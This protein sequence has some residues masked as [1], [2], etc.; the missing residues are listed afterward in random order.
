VGD[1]KGQPSESGFSILGPVS[2]QSPTG[3]SDP[4]RMKL[5]FVVILCFVELAILFLSSHPPALPTHCG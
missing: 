4:L 3:V 5:A 1:H 2:Y